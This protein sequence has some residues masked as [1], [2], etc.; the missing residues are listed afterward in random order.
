MAVIPKAKKARHGFVHLSFQSDKDGRELLSF[1]MTAA[2]AIDYAKEVLDA[3]GI[4]SATLVQ[5]GEVESVDVTIAMPGIVRF[6]SDE[7]WSVAAG[8]AGQTITVRAR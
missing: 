8:P 1:G 4:V 3:A 5:R 7:A 6:S 2:D